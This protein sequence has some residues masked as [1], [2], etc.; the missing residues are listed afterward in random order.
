MKVAVQIIAYNEEAT[1]AAVLR[2]WIGKVHTI[3]VFHS[4]KPWHGQELPHDRTQRICEDMQ[5]EFIRLPWRSE[6]EQRNWALARHYDFD[7]VLIVDADE[8]YTEADQFTL[9]ET[10]GKRN[11][12]EMHDN[13]WCYRVGRVETYFKTPEWIM[14]PPDRH[15]PV[16]AIDPKKAIF[17]DCRIPSTQYQIPLPIT[18]HHLSYLRDEMRLYHK[19]QQ[20]EHHDRV[21]KGYFDTFK[22][23]KP[24]DKT[25]VRA[26]ESEPSIAV[27][28]KMPEELCTLLEF[29]KNT[30]DMLK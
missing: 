1:I 19:L 4:D 16:V 15:R 28:G 20:F 13:L 23:W 29:N 30:L 9:L 3:T 7:Y 11:D 17:T 26:H 21:K 5:I 2:N 22:N 8:L 18:M 25:I 14:D 27:P 10:I 6:T 24:G 12:A